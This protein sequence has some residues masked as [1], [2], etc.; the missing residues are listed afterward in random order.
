MS[1]T[2]PHTS[3]SMHKDG[4]QK[5]P[6]CASR[7]CCSY[8]TRSV[9]LAPAPHRLMPF[10]SDCITLPSGPPL[11]RSVLGMVAEPVRKEGDSVLVECTVYWETEKQAHGAGNPKQ[12]TDGVNTHRLSVCECGGGLGG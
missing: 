1:W 3:E 5:G 2:G 12:E 8:C 9:R 4:V 10:H 6:P 11:S 7:L